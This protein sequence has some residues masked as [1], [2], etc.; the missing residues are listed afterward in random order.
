M[1]VVSGGMKEESIFVCEPEI[2]CANPDKGERTIKINAGM[3][4][5][6]C[7]LKSRYWNR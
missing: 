6:L 7:I 5:Q 1:M 4:V 3:N 2:S